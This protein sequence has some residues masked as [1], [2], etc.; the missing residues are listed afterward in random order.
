[1]VLDICFKLL[2]VDEHVYHVGI[3]VF[4]IHKCASIK[5]GDV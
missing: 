3:D 4:W 1:M 2:K 5:A